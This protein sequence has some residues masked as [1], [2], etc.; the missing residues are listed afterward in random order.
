MPGPFQVDSAIHGLRTLNRGPFQVGADL[1]CI[2]FS[3]FQVISAFVSADNGETWTQTGSTK[4]VSSFTCSFGCCLS[5]GGDYLYVLYISTF[6]QRLQ[7]SRFNLALGDFDLDSAAG[8]ILN[9]GAGN[10]PYSFIEQSIDG[11][12]VAMVKDFDAINGDATVA[13]A[14]LS[15]GLGT[16]STLSYPNGQS[17]D[18]T[19]FLGAGLVRGGSDRVHGFALKNSGAGTFLMHILAYGG[20]GGVGSEFSEIAEVVSDS[21]DPADVVSAAAAGSLIGVAF[22]SADVGIG[23]PQAVSVATAADADSPSFTVGVVDDSTVGT[24][25][26]SK[27]ELIGGDALRLIYHPSGGDVLY[28]LYSGSWSSPETLFTPSDTLQ[29]LDG[30]DLESGF[31]FFFA[32]TDFSEENPPSFYFEVPGGAT[33]NGAAGIPSEEAFGKTHGVSGGG[34]PESCGGDPVVIP[35]A[36]GCNSLPTV[37]YY[38]GDQDSCPTRGYSY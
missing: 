6:P 17:D 20:S 15:V 7:V 3:A 28:S 21:G 29:A 10:A 13:L 9:S 32:D 35:P 11:T 27:L 18:D 33:I 5:T 24:E 38:P 37:P 36:P 14:T 25:D 8:P 16:W 19:F 1:Y 23:D 34:E 26:G 31:G 2:A 4:T 30:F 12:L 22:N